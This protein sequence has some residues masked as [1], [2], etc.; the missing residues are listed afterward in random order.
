MSIRFGVIAS[1]EVTAAEDQLDGATFLRIVDAVSVVA[2]RN[3][4]VAS[5][6]GIKTAIANI[7]G[8]HRNTEPDEWFYEAITTHQ[9]D[10]PPDVMVRIHEL[11]GGG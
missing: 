11:F 7:L 2:R 1:N 9:I 4:P 8:A 5:K 6:H 3:T 10:F